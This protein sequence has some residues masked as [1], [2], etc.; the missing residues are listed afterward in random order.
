MFSILSRLGFI[1]IFSFFLIVPTSA[2][3][4]IGRENK[5]FILTIEAPGTYEFSTALSL[6]TLNEYAPAE[7]YTRLER[8]NDGNGNPDYRI[9]VSYDQNGNQIYKAF[10]RNADGNAED[11]R[12]FTFNNSNQKIRSEFDYDADGNIDNEYT[13]TYDAAGNLTREERDTDM[14]QIPNYIA[15]FTYDAAG[16]L[17][18]EQ[19]DSDADGTIDY[20]LSLAYDSYGN[21][22][23]EARDNDFNGVMDYFKKLSY[24]AQ[25]NL[26]FEATDFQGDGIYD[27]I[28]S[29]Q[30]NAD[31]NPIR[32]ERDNNGDEIIDEVTLYTYD[33]NGYVSR[34]EVDEDADG[35]PDQIFAVK[36]D[37]D[38]KLISNQIDSDAD[39]VFEGVQR[40]SYDKNGNP[41][42]IEQDIDNNGVIE[43]QESLTHFNPIK[44]PDL[45]EGLAHKFEVTIP[46]SGVWKFSL[47]GST[48]Q[49]ILALSDTE[50]GDSNLVYALDGCPNGDASA[51]VSIENA[52]TYYLTIAGKGPTDKGDYSLEI[53]RMHGLNVLNLVQGEVSVYPNPASNTIAVNANGRKI[54]TFRIMNSMGQEV[55]AGSYVNSPIDIASLPS[56]IYWITLEERGN[57]GTL[58]SKFVK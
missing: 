3:F 28:N 12:I 39:G 9:I 27:R 15:T 43:L 45:G 50:N 36:F 40:F 53:T 25:G 17:I 6:S 10:D 41:S 4:D 52:G 33:N 44:C 8:D 18:K 34:V 49:N 21:L 11:I 22:I 57:R 35:A 2:Q 30:Y 51:N 58:Y 23:Q 20:Q 19:R 14:D 38:G 16:N 26:I 55:M 47:C 24:D 54:S 1:V 31:G 56:G 48:F 37:V 5:P 7:L 29:F 13:F 32:E 42:R 46:E